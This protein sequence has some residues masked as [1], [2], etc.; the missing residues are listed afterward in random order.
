MNNLKNDETT[1]RA[2][3]AKTKP[4]TI[5]FTD[6]EDSTKLWD[7]HGDIKGRLMVDRHNRL[8]FPIVKKFRGRIIKTIGD[9]IMAAFKNPKAAIKTAIAMQQILADE[10]HKDKR[11]NLKIR[12]G[13][14]TGEA[15]VEYK[16][17]FGD[18]VNVASRIEGLCTGNQILIS[19]RTA[20]MLGRHDF[21]L[22]NRGSSILKGKIKKITLYSVNWE[23][24]AWIA[25]A[26][27]A[28]VFLPIVLKQKI[29][30]LIYA[31]I[32]GFTLYYIY[33]KFIRFVF[34][35]SE[36]V[37]LILL[38]P[39][40]FLSEYPLVFGIVSI[41]IFILI[42]LLF[43]MK[44]IPLIILKLIK[45]GFGFS[46]VFFLLYIPA[47]FINIVLPPEW[48]Q[49]IF[50]S[51]HT[52]VEVLEENVNIYKQANLKAEILKSVN[53]GTLLLLTNVYEQGKLTWNKVLIGN[54][55]FGWIL[56]TMP[57]QF[58]IPETTLTSAN[59]FFIYYKDVFIFFISMLGFLWGYSK[60]K[61]NPA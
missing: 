13:I 37:A 10:R 43:K 32:S 15:I 9:S 59:K 55:K 58:G 53:R 24:Y 49:E 56:K 3:R 18:V 42:T 17:V 4:V 47:T 45:G 2:I 41:L 29:E 28:T 51:D 20:D 36:K 26:F 44:T 60:F 30:T 22:T 57:A 27:K 61:V 16:D 34:I 8:L 40:D 19:Q 33:Q 25:D 48:N 11:F 5:L 21:K 38:N 35:D 39:K 46:L 7:K 31:I 54:N 23:M 14:H 6:I 1:I 50:Q 12:I 52:F